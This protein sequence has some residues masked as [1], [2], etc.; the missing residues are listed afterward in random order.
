MII[1]LGVGFGVIMAF[2]LI[3]DLCSIFVRRH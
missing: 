2:C 1:L 3:K